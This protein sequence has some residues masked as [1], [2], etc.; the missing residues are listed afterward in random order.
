MTTKKLLTINE[1]REACCISRSTVYRLFE[2]K[3]LNPV[4]IG[5]SVRVRADELNDWLASLHD[6]AA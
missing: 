2:R 4:Y 3:E 6:R 5:K 1:V